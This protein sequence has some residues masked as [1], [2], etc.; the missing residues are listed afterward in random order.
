M[1][2]RATGGRGMC[3]V[4]VCCVCMLPIAS[5]PNK[6]R[7]IRYQVLGTKRR[8]HALAQRGSDPAVQ[9]M[10]RS[11]LL[12]GC[13][14]SA[15]AGLRRYL[16]HAPADLPLRDIA[17]VY[18]GTLVRVWRHASSLPCSLALLL[19]CALARACVLSLSTR[20]QPMKSSL[21]SP[22]PASQSN[23][24]GKRLRHQCRTFPLLPVL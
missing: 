14:P 7:N 24:C 6:G 15:P 5:H 23:S 2:V 22:C 11:P 1:R 13:P 8:A 4:Y 20:K 21:S 12:P 18:A 3:V 10:C 9:A 19:S 17:Y 16:T